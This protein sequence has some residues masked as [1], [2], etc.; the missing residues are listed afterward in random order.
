MPFQF[1]CPYCF[2]KTLVD[3]SIAGHS[4][5]CA[6]CGKT[7]KVPEPPAKFTPTLRSGDNGQPA[8]PSRLGKRHALAWGLKAVGLLVGVGLLSLISIQLLWP[9]LTSLKARHD[10]VTSLNNLQRIAQALNEYAAV[11]GS[12]PPPVVCNA[13]GQPLY[14]W[15]VLILKELGEEQVFS[16]FRLDLPWDAPENLETLMMC[17]L[18]YQSPAA[19]NMSTGSESHYA[20]VTGKQT[21]F[22]STGSL[23]PKDI[24]DGKR[25]TLLLVETNNNITEWSRPWDVDIAKMN[26]K[27]GATGPNTIGG[28]HAGG[29]AVVFADGSPGWLPE[30]LPPALLKG[31]VSPNGGEPINS[32]D[33][34]LQ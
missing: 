28:M 34:Q 16:K 13:A 5:P 11:Y 33:Y 7:I 19:A 6:N 4:G 26:T 30:D 14:S 23:S 12:Y 18:V 3:E 29:A 8:I 1:T 15:R 25:N 32:A 9:T 2:K 10:K 31:L 20:L 21:L 22:P 27:I 17:P 24:P